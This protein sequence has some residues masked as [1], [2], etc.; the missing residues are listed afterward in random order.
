MS[1][2]SDLVQLLN[3]LAAERVYWDN[4]PEGTRVIADT[5]LLETVG[6]R[7]RGLY[8]EKEVAD[9]IHARVRV[10]VIGPDFQTASDLSRL[11]EK[12]IVESVVFNAE[13]FGA[14]TRTYVQGVKLYEVRQDFG[15]L[16]PDP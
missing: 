10:T 16:Y 2:E 11:I 1:F 5:I 4:L 15:I 12:T 9:T 3:P 8:L 7:G 14:F 13:A 6:G